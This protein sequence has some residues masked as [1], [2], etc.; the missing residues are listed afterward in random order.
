MKLSLGIPKGSLEESTVGLF[1]KAGIHIARSS[2]S[3]YPACDDPELD[4]IVMRPQEIPRYVQQG[5]IDA[6]ITGQDWVAENEAD[7][8]EV[9]ELHYSKVSRKKCKWVLAVPEDS[10]FQQATDLNG[11]RI[12]T[13]LVGTTKRYFASK[14]VD[15]SV[16]FSWGATEAKPPRL[17]DAIVDITETGS[18]LRANR[19]R[20]IDVLMETCTVIVANKNS[21]ADEEKRGKL[22]NLKMLLLGTLD[23]ENYVGL[24]C[25]VE[26]KNLEHIIK[27]LPALN[28]PTVSQLSNSGWCAVET[29]LPFQQTKHV[30]PLLKRAGAS[31]IVEYPVSKII[32]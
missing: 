22:E 5:I 23:A 8:I 6:G 27:I 2:R 32:A 13:E 20:I 10:P 19:L 15:I 9:T 1:N 21:W 31:G 18:S 16:E 17:A 11:K 29:I 7:V 14:N 26:E 30:I 24:K 28:N 4:L 25:N 3:Y 12:A